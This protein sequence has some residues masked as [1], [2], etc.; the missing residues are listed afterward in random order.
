MFQG[1]TVMGIFVGLLTPLPPE[2]SI[3]LLGMVGLHNLRVL[4]KSLPLISV[5][6]PFDVLTVS[7]SGPSALAFLPGDLP[8]ALL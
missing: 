2:C 7:S 8:H 4:F 5:S 6:S 3:T 1:D